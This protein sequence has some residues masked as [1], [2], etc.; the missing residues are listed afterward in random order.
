MK[1]NKVYILFPLLIIPIIIYSIFSEPSVPVKGFKIKSR[2]FNE[3]IVVSGTVTS[4][5]NSILSTEIAGKITS[6]LYKEGDFVKKD[7]ILLTLDTSKLDKDILQSEANLKLVKN[8]FLKLQNID[9]NIANAEYAAAFANF[10]IFEKQYNKFKELYNKKMISELEFQNQEN[11]YLNAKNKLISSKST[12]GSLSSGPSKEISK[13]NIE[14]ATL[15]VEA[16]KKQKEKLILKAPYDGI[17]TRKYMNIGEVVDI[18]SK[19]FNFYSLTDK[20]IE[21]N[22]DEK[23]LSSVS[24][25]SEVYIYASNNRVDLFKGKIYYIGND[26]DQDNGTAEIKIKILENEKDFV[27]G[28]TVNAIINTVN[29]KNQ[30]LIPNEYILNEDLKNY[31]YLINN[32]IIEKK[33]VKLKNVLNNNLVISGISEND[34][35]IKEFNLKP[36]IKVK[37]VVEN[38]I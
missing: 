19:L 28:S 26:I 17:I 32:G 9:S 15:Q 3:K 6:I 25:E 37:M 8:E 4:E 27:F 1:F 33:E 12:L 36:G 35:L 16:L 34:I 5:N 10:K 13:N 38:E 7:D 30:L 2:D 22:L 18:K 11:I 21:I 14:I 20:Y 29:I 31:V 23:Y 24:L